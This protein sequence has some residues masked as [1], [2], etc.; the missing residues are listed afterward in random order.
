M[1]KKRLSVLII[2]VMLLTNFTFLSSGVSYADAPQ[3]DKYELASDVLAELFEIDKQLSKVGMNLEMLKKIPKKD[4]QYYEELV[5]HMI[6]ITSDTQLKLDLA[7]IMS[8]S[9]IPLPNVSKPSQEAITSSDQWVYALQMAI[10]NKKRDSNVKDIDKEAMY[11]YMSHYIDIPTGII[12]NGVDKSISNEQYFSSWITLDDRRVYDVYM[13]GM[14][15]IDTMHGIANT[16]LN[17]LDF[18]SSMEDVQGLLLNLEDFR[19]KLGKASEILLTD[20][21]PSLDDI[22]NDY[23]NFSDILSR[24]NDPYQAAN[25]ITKSL[26]E[27]YNYNGRKANFKFFLSIGFSLGKGDIIGAL[28]TTLLNAGDFLNH[29][30]RD[31]F[32]RVWWVA[33]LRTHSYR[34]AMRLNRYLYN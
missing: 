33:L 16:A 24:N 5:R 21:T 23:N 29:T 25:D 6:E 20:G 31:L 28:G 34:V 7:Q 2:F 22:A 3:K 17:V 9:K 10:Q 13:N 8:D 1:I 12:V 18:V 30:I 19:A 15:I 14:K 26:Q 27:G 4:H 32:N 11:M